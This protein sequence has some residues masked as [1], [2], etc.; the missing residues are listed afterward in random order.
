MHRWAFVC[1][2][3]TLMALE[4]WANGQNGPK[5]SQSLDTTLTMLQN[6]PKPTDT[7]IQA[8]ASETDFPVTPNNVQNNNVFNIVVIGDSIAWGAGLTK[9][10]KYSYLVAKEIAEQSGRAVNVKVLA[11]TGATLK[12]TTS[13]R[14][15][16][17]PDIPSS[18]PTLFGQVDKIS[19]PDDVDLALV[20]GGANDVDLEKINS[21]DYGLVFNTILG[22]STLDEIETQ[23]WDKIETPM[24]EL[25]KKLLDRCPHAKIVVTGYYSAISKDSKELTKFYK[26]FAPESQFSRSDYK[27]ADDP[28]QLYEL[29]TKANTFYE[30]SNLAL[31]SAK[32][33]VNKESGQNRIEFARIV[34]PPDKSYGTDN[35]WL[36][37]IE[38]NEGN[39]KTDD[40][41]YDV[42]ASLAGMVCDF[43]NRIPVCDD[44]TESKLAAVGHPNVEGA[45]EYYR[46][47]VQKISETWLDLLHPMVLDFQVSPP[48]VTSGKLFKISYRV[49][50]NCSEGLKQVELWRTQDKD[51]WPKDSIQTKVLAGQTG[52]FSG[53]FTD[54]PS[55]PGKYWYGVHVVDNVDNW[56]DERNSNSEGQPRSFE[57]V[58]V[59]VIS[60]SSSSTESCTPAITNVKNELDKIKMTMDAYTYGSPLFFGSS[61]QSSTPAISFD[62]YI[63][64]AEHCTSN[65]EAS[66]YMTSNNVQDGVIQ[67]TLSIISYLGFARTGFCIVLIDYKYTA[68]GVP[69]SMRYPIVCNE[70][71]EPYWQSWQLYG[72]FNQLPTL[73]TTG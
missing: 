47:I 30:K 32:S 34:F 15:I 70:K 19:N 4:G 24:Y 39:Y 10:E 23:S 66:K 1:I 28:T 12:K 46:T 33:R 37:K 73:P 52:P 17:Y 11:H 44:P 38:G 58:E 61:G 72:K 3:L 2:V 56:N 54:S 35:S 60:P 69:V 48:S 14:E 50:S 57:P 5:D 29:A 25:L 21:L 18:N 16:Q 20:S 68:L 64:G 27:N 45:A 41:K 22:G 42:R 7:I 40:H 49:S 36:W 62:Y 71:G 65:S 43:T 9:Y 6:E 63:I 51:K 67:E 59:E 8:S 31:N 55:T 13:D 26:A 53:L